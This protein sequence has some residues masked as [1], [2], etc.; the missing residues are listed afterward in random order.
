MWFLRQKLVDLLR[1]CEGSVFTFC[2]F[3]NLFLSVVALPK[4]RDTGL[5][6]L[7]GIFLETKLLYGELFSSLV[8]ENSEDPLI[9]FFFDVLTCS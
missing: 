2:S 6:M 8:P 4:A 1:Y 5:E 3:D 7:I 9:Y